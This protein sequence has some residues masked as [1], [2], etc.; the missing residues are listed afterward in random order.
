MVNP[1]AHPVRA[2]LKVLPWLLGFLALGL[3][4][5]W[6]SLSDIVPLMHMLATRAQVV[7]FQP[8]YMLTL[9]LTG[10]FLALCVNTLIV[11]VRLAAHGEPGRPRG[12]QRGVDPTV[13][14][15]G[16]GLACAAM[17]PLAPTIGKVMVARAAAQR[18][19]VLCP[20]PFTLAH[21]PAMRWA[22]RDAVA[23]CS[24]E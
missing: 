13:V 3:L 19:Y 11:G 9:P 7:S 4:S 15:V 5:L 12:R 16:V 2:S 8:R 20:V 6:L 14:M 23:R 21:S 17:A 24:A 18:G 1:L 22:R 10:T